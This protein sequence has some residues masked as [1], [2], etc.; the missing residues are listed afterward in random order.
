MYTDYEDIKEQI[1]DDASTLKGKGLCTI[2][3]V[4]TKL[5]HWKVEQ[6]ATTFILYIVNHP[7]VLV[8]KAAECFGNSYLWIKICAHNAEYAFMNCPQ[9]Y[10]I[11]RFLNIAYI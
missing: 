5:Q 2:I 3:I 1:A 4:D 7:S 11:P 8:L 9:V 10:E 6:R